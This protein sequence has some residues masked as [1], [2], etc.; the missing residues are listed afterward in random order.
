VL[1]SIIVADKVKIPHDVFEYRA[2]AL[3]VHGRSV[4]AYQ[5]NVA[6]PGLVTTSRIGSKASTNKSPSTAQK[7]WS[8]GPP[9]LKVL[10][11][12]VVAYQMNVAGPGI[13]ATFRIGMRASTNLS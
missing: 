10:G 3:K 11:R 2:L 1:G 6:G 7:Y 12:S 8:Y 13:A 9:T 4:L 5:I